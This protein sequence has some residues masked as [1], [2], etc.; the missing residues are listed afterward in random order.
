VNRAAAAFRMN[1]ASLANGANPA[2]I[3]LLVTSDQLIDEV[4]VPDPPK[5]AGASLQHYVS[6]AVGEARRFEA[7]SA[8]SYLTL[9]VRVTDFE[10]PS[11]LTVTVTTSFLPFAFFFSL[12]VHPF[13]PLPASGRPASV[14]LQL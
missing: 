10:T 3:R 5:T 12:N 1:T 11:Y 7:G 4:W 6:K 14:A 2:L 13:A 9:Y 8:A